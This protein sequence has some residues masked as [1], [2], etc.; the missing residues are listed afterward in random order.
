MDKTLFRLS[1]SEKADI[2]FDLLN[3]NFNEGQVD[4]LVCDVYDDYALCRSKEG[5]ARVYYSKN[6][7]NVSVGEMV[8]VKIVDV[9]E[10]EYAALEAIK[11]TN[12]SY[13]VAKTA[14]EDNQNKIVELEKTVE[15]FKSSQENYQ[16][17]IDSKDKEIAEYKETITGLEAEKAEFNSKVVEFENK[18]AEI[19]KANSELNSVNSELVEF[20]KSIETE[21]KKAILDKYEQ[22]LSES[23]VEEL[24][25]KINS[26]SVEDFK[27]EVCTA[28]VE[29]DN[30][31]F[32]KRDSEPKIVYKNESGA[33]VTTTGAIGLIEK[34]KNGGNK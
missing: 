7:D 15:E 5:F 30:S 16:N 19:E 31:I 14:F 28:A 20:K 21:K 4:Y 25:S 27:K 32:E 11:A 12:G 3:P 26:F 6:E 13:E 17:S 8:S 9:T 10:T 2:L 24:N 18:I 23:M 1:D 34:Y 33:K 22:Y 29:S